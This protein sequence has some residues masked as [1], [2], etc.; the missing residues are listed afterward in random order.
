MPASG[1]AAPE[2]GMTNGSTPRDGVRLEPMPCRC[3]VIHTRD[4]YENET[5][6]IEWCAFHCGQELQ[7]HYAQLLNMWDGGQRLTF[8][9]GADWT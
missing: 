7:S 5:F 2:D 6:R 3:A 8:E 4:E 9:D 1:A